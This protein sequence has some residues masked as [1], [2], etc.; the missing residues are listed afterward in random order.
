MKTQL[1]SGELDRMA[2]LDGIRSCALVEAPSGLVWHAT[3]HAGR[4]HLWEAAIDYWRLHQRQ[5]VHF[6]ALGDLHAAVM[7]HRHEVLAV[8]PCTR[9][10]ELLV[11]CVATH[12]GVDWRVWQK[13]VRELAGRIEASMA[14]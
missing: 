7:Y 4:E 3:A 1:I 9:E 10:P 14:R 12:A 6:K 13:L 2:T 5:R 8:L 11:V